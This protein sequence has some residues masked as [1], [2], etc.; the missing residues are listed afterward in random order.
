MQIEKHKKKWIGLYIASKV[1]EIFTMDHNAKIAIIS[2]DNGF[3]AVLDYWR[4]RLSVQNQ[5][6]KSKSIA[7]SLVCV[8][9]ES[10]RKLLVNE[11]M[12]T[13]KLQEVYAK[14]E[15]RNRMV[16]GITDLFAGTDYETLIFQ[17]VDIVILS[18]Q[19]KIMYL[20]FLKRFG[21]KNGT[22]VYRKIKNSDISIK[23]T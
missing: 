5:L 2:A 22:E 16:I 3:Q 21:R 11:S 4:P 14:Y 8:S 13:F 18:N 7:K 19:P 12:E 1:G 20:N 15:E 10:A 9:G 17:I 6:V 23:R